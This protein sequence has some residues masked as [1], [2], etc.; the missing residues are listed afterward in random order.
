MPIIKTVKGDLI[1]MFKDQEFDEI[2]HGCNCFHLMGAG[3]AGQIAKC[4][5]EALEADR[6]T[7][8]D[9]REKLG[10]FSSVNTDF[11]VIINAY[12]QYRPGREHPSTLYQAIENVFKTING[13]RM[14]ND[15]YIT[16]IPRI[17]AGIA[18]GDWYTISRIID[19]VSPNMNI[20]LVDYQPEMIR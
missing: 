20:V 13:H 3:I 18:G 14:K 4:F 6:T 17:G 16:G 11:G 7:L 9:E 19:S 12:T 2:M 1:R 5:P 10:T 15:D 8:V